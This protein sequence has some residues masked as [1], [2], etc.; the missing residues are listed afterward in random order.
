MQLKPEDIRVCKFLKVVNLSCV[1]L[2][3]SISISVHRGTQK[4]CLST[5]CICSAVMQIRPFDHLSYSPSLREGPN[6]RRCGAAGQIPISIM[7]IIQR[8]HCQFDL[9]HFQMIFQRQACF[10]CWF[11]LLTHCFSR[12]LWRPEPRYADGRQKRQ[13]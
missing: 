5:A 9:L 4:R 10:C 12:P 13:Q 8:G 3:N 7:L 2:I 6:E 1:F 11:R